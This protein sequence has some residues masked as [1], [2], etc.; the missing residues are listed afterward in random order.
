MPIVYLSLS[1][2]NGKPSVDP[3]ELQHKLRGIAHVAYPE[4]TAAADVLRNAMRDNQGNDHAPYNGTAELI[5]SPAN[6]KRFHLQNYPEPEKAVYPL[7]AEL[8]KRL[9]TDASYRELAWFTVKLGAVRS[10][11]RELKEKTDDMAMRLEELRASVRTRSDEEIDHLFDELSARLEEEE[12]RRAAAEAE[13]RR[14]RDIAESKSRKSK[15]KGIFIAANENELY[16]GELLDTVLTALRK[17]RDSL[18][19][20]DSDNAKSRMCMLIASMLEANPADGT[21]ERI[22]DSIAKA[23]EPERN[24]SDSAVQKLRKLGL[25]EKPSS[26]GKHSKYLFHGDDRYPIS[27][28]NTPSDVWTRKNEAQ[29]IRKLL[30][31]W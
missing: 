30:F 22:A 7:I 20:G 9:I 14:L 26:D 23:I 5:V 31:P 17:H 11:N 4:S 12:E 16:Q 2:R 27:L 24:L 8:R 28:A 3:D 18:I 13:V 6:R 15:Q 10:E 19:S 1:M 25:E 21:G 29:R